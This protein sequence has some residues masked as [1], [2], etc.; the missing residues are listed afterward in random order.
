MKLQSFSN[1]VEQYSS[2]NPLPVL[3]VGHGN[4]MEA[5]TPRNG[6]PYVTALAKMGESVRSNYSINAILMISAHWLTNGTYVNNSVQPKMIYDIPGFPAELYHVNYPAPGAPD[7]ANEVKRL[8]PHVHFTNDWGLDHAC[9]SVLVHMFPNADI[10]VFE[11]SIDYHK[12]MGYH[13]ELIQKLGVLR[14]KGV[15]V[16]SSG[17]IVH[18]L[19]LGI[20]KMRKDDQ[21]P[22]GWEAEFDNWVKASLDKKDFQSLLHYE[23]LGRLA[24]L[25]VPTPDHYIP[26]IYSIGLANEKDTVSQTYE[27]IIPGGSLRSFMIH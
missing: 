18:N 25:S 19:Q 24:E 17:S 23:K 3:Y 11:M 5:L 12:P 14:R 15:L 22:Y 9:W 8:L 1:V 2:T 27:E 20:M 16:I 26:M 13:F 10:P 4:P 6:N 21:S 7:T